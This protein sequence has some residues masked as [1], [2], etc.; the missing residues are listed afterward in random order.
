MFDKGQI[1]DLKHDRGRLVQAITDA[2]GP[3]VFVCS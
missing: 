3:I 1:A 2:G